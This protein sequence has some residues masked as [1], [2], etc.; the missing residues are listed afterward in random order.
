MKMK[1]ITL[2]RAAMTLLFATFTT[3][4]AWAENEPALNKVDGVYQI[5][6]VNDW[7]TLAAYVEDGNDCAEMTF[8][9]TG[10]IGSADEPITRP[11]GRQLGDDKEKDRMRFAGTFDGGSHT[12]YIAINTDPEGQNATNWFKYDGKDHKGYCSPFV[13]VKNA[14]IKNLHVAG[15]VT[16]TGQWASGLVGS[17]GYDKND[18]ACTIENCQVSVAITANYVSA[19]G[20][21]GNHGGFIG[22]AEGNA[23]ISNSWFDG[24]FL[25]KDYQYS[26]GFIGINKV[27]ATINNCLFN[28]SEIN[29][30][31]NKITGSCEF[32]HD[33]G[34]SHTLT[35]AYWVSHFGEPENAQ[36]QKVVAEVAIEIPADGE[37]YSYY[38]EKV[39]AADFNADINNYYYI[40]KHNPTWE[41]LVKKMANGGQIDLH[42]VITAGTEDKALVVP[43]GK[44]FTLS[45]DGTLDRDLMLGTAQADGYVIAVAEGGK[46]ILN[47]GTIK[48]GHNT[49]NGAGIYNEGE[50]IIN[51]STIT[52]NFTEGNGGGIYNAGTL[53]INGATI[54]DNSG[55]NST[56]KGIGVYSE[57]S[58]SIEGNVKIK[59]NYYT[60]YQPKQMKVPHNLYLEG[61]A[62]MNIAGS[63]NGS[64]I[65]VEVGERTN[66]ALAFTNGLN[67]KG[68]KG[69]FF[70]DM[71]GIYVFENESG[72][73][74][75]AN[76]VLELANESEIENKNS[77]I[78]N[79]NNGKVATV[80]LKGRTL[81]G[82]NTW[83]TLC[84]PFSLTSLTGT[85]LEGATVMKLDTDNEHDGDK[86]GFSN[87]TLN[88]FFQTAGN[89]IEAGKPYLVKWETG[90]NVTDPEFKNVIIN[91][92]TAQQTI[93]SKDKNVS[94]VGSYDTKSIGST[95]DN[96][97]L[98]V[99]R[100]DKN[101]STLYYPNGA[102]TIGAC[103]AYFQLNNGIVA[104]E[105]KDNTGVR[106]IVMNFD[107][108]TTG[109]VTMAKETEVL[110]EGWFS[111]DGMKLYKQP[112]TKGLYILNG[113]KV[114]VK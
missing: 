90:D 34:G 43:A 36:G 25:G 16:T 7:N 95:G 1:T 78:I 105:P 111:L 40:I 106:T 54:T 13:Y 2:A 44:E 20:H 102:M 48:G 21:Y 28:P 68:N 62:V 85:P 37:D 14:T 88:L 49:G 46:L 103:R 84:L 18:G 113:R 32:S 112:T 107:D 109:I 76:L 65:G 56:N 31:N 69:N 75:L 33:I 108:E 23:T 35:D 22:I 86:T 6:T 38:V 79:D 71:T 17:T 94:F 51:G 59:D 8:L 50:L 100:N 83:N 27:T 93:T 41:D 74:Y 101:E 81:F 98:Y 15:S 72:E 89:K 60:Y 4:G 104:G 97:I 26:A 5:T 77:N 45:L 10:N 52:G 3:A 73:A 63:I 58:F 70:S 110:K 12:L 92:N 30:E 99:G 11:I 114:V 96:T 61:D 47:G 9:M 57:N 67:G 19:N 42:A 80:V 39:E 53:T 87:G 82:N 29:I 55:K 24:K 64:S 91:K 66:D